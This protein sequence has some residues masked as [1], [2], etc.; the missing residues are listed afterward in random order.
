MLRRG[1]LPRIK[2]GHATRILR[3]DIDAYIEAH[4]EGA[5]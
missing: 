3:R 2:I 5:A 4:R 1:D